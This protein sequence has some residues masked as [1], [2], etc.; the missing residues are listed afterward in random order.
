ML[1]AGMGTGSSRDTILNSL[2]DANM[3]VTALVDESGTVVERYAYDPYGRVT[4]LGKGKGTGYFL[5]LRVDEADH[6]AA[7][8]G[9]CGLRL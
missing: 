2:N 3:N 9:R 1:W 5:V 7:G 4:V 6:P 8:R